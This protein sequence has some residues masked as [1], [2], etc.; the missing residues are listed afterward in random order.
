MTEY[1]IQVATNKHGFHEMSQYESAI[2]I[3]QRLFEKT[4]LVRNYTQYNPFDYYSAIAIAL[5]KENDLVCGF[6]GLY[7]H[8]SLGVLA[9]SY[10]LSANRQQGLWSQMADTLLT[11]SKEMGLSKVIANPKSKNVNLAS[12]LEK[13]GFIKKDHLYELVFD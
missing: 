5:E 2:V 12:K 7:R 4:V 10:V 13:K 1:Q 11:K 6:M 3:F 9:A 8:R